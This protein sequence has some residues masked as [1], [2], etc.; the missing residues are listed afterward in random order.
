MGTVINLN[1]Q[2]L[3]R[4]GVPEAEARAQVGIA[5][6]LR[7]HKKMMDARDSIN[8]APLVEQDLPCE[9]DWPHRD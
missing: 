7:E 5:N 1:V 8:V 2:K 9:E 4:L 3:I 6:F